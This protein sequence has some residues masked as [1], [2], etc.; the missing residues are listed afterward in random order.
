[1]SRLIDKVWNINLAEYE[2][3]LIEVDGDP[4]VETR[5]EVVATGDASWAIRTAEHFDLVL[6]EDLRGYFG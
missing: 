6:P 5:G 2:W 3:A 1:M 4:K